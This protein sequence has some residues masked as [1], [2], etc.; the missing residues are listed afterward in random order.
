MDLFYF[1]V[2]SLEQYS[3]KFGFHVNY[4]I[5]KGAFTEAFLY[6][7]A[8]GVVVA[9]AFY[10]S[11][12]NAVSV[13]PAT[14]VNW[15]IGLVIVAIA[16]FFIGDI[17]VIGSEGNPGTG[18]YASCQA[19]ANNYMLLHQDNNQAIQECQNELNKILQDLKEDNDIVLLFN[20]TN[21]FLS[22]L[23]YFLVSLSVKNF[24]KH[25][26]QIPF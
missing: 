8:I 19:F 11:L 17:M 15:F 22:M 7:L 9:L 2:T 1:L 13:K 26:S 4:F 23:I 24:T 16:A 25:G 21:A 5:E 6:S 3:D 10:F 14:R 18:F 12:C 20:V